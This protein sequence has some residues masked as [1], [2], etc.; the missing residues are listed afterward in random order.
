MQNGTPTNGA[1]DPRPAYIFVLL[2]RDSPDHELLLRVIGQALPGE[3]VLTFDTSQRAASMLK[4]GIRPRVLFVDAGAVRDLGPI[5]GALRA[6][7]PEL[8]I[9]ALSDRT[10]ERVSGADQ[11]VEKNFRDG[12]DALAM[13][14][15]VGAQFAMSSAGVSNLKS[16]M[17]D[18]LTKWNG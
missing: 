11:T 3:T 15:R 5:V 17:A 8:P 10:A 4:Q 13:R 18:A 9:V 2:P 1:T 6:A 12:L 7:V 14:V 16:I